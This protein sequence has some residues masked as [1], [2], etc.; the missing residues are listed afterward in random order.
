MGQYT[1]ANSPAQIFQMP[2]LPFPDFPDGIQTWVKG[3]NLN[4]PTTPSPPIAAIV[5]TQ[6]I[7]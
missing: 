7:L 6:G 4:Y 5:P 1:S 2:V 3:A